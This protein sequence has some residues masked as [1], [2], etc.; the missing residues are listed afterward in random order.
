MPSHYYVSPFVLLLWSSLELCRAECT[1]DYQKLSRGGVTHTACKPPNPRCH[2][3]E[4][5]LR[6]GEAEEIL[7][8]HNA[9]RSRMALGLVPGF[10][11]AANMR[12]LRAIGTGWD[13]AL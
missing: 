13:D 7:R 4:R 12:Q 6:G 2:I 1:P 10:K 5:G 11:P 3:I 9:Y 8:L